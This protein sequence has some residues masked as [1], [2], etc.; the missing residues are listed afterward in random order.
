MQSFLLKA[1]A[2]RREGREMA[3]VGSGDDGTGGRVNEPLEEGVARAH[4]VVS[5][6][7]MKYRSEQRS[8]EDTI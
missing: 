6:V 8:A 3:A 5:R 1:A 7:L 4:D 2:R